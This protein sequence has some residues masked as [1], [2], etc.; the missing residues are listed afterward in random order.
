MFDKVPSRWISFRCDGVFFLF[1]YRTT[2]PLLFAASA[3]SYWFAFSLY[4]NSYSLVEDA[5]NMMEKVYKEG[6]ILQKILYAPAA[7]LLYVGA[8][9]ERYG[10]TFIAAVVTTVA[11]VFTM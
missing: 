5:I 2:D 3:L 1:V 6:N 4:V 8:Y 9:L 10:V 11:L 7:A